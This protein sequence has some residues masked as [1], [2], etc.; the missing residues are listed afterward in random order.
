MKDME[1]GNTI[2]RNVE[3]LMKLAKL[4]KVKSRLERK[5][6]DENKEIARGVSLH[7]SM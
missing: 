1:T 2:E 5:G 3:R 7:T 6:S 4:A